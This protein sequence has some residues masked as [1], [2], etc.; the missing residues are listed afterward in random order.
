MT[1]LTTKRAIMQIKIFVRKGQYPFT[2]NLTLQ[3]IASNFDAARFCEAELLCAFYFAFHNPRCN[4]ENNPRLLAGF[5]LVAEGEDAQGWWAEYSDERYGC[6][7]PFV[8]FAYVRFQAHEVS[9]IV[10]GC[11]DHYE[12]GQ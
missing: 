3:S 1:N 2:D 5:A 9:K 11:P 12:E 8:S 6:G 7:R 4:F 10:R